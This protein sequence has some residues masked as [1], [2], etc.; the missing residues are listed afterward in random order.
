ML[1]AASLYWF[2]SALYFSPVP[3]APPFDLVTTADTVHAAALSAPLLRTLA[4]LSLLGRPPS[5]PAAAYLALEHRDRLLVDSFLASARDD[6][7]FKL[8]QVDH[9]R[10]ERLVERTGAEGGTRAWQDEAD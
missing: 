9:A 4:H 8:A 1:V 7:G 10:L 3:L 2:R 6:H 5:S